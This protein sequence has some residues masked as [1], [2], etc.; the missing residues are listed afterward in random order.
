MRVTLERAAQAIDRKA[1]AVVAETRRAEQEALADGLKEARRLSSGAYS[2]RQLRAMGHPY[3]RRRGGGGL[4]GQVINVQ[5]GAFRAGWRIQGRRLVNTRGAAR[6]L[7]ARGTRTM[8]GRPIQAAVAAA[9][10]AAGRRRA[11][12]AARRAM[13]R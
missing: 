5:T 12:A 9:L 10:A 7:M 2:A 8:I 6:W 1:R 3:A 13:R 11:L 4:P